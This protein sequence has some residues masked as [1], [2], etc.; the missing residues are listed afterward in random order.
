MRHIKYFFKIFNDI[1]KQDLKILISKLHLYKSFILHIHIMLENL[2]YEPELNKNI[3]LYLSYLKLFNLKSDIFFIEIND[4]LL[5]KLDNDINKKIISYLYNNYFFKVSIFDY[6]C[7]NYEFDNY[8]D[9]SKN[10]LIEILNELLDNYSDRNDIL[11]ERKLDVYDDQYDIEYPESVS[12]NIKELL[13][14][15]NIILN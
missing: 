7:L 11:N 6:V 2:S 13:L 15:D 10:K 4:V 3:N 9:N 5:N 8:D 12:I 14:K 1:E